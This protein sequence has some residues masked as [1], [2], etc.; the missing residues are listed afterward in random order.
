METYKPEKC[1]AYPCKFKSYYVV[2]K[3]FEELFVPLTERS[4]NRTM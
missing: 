2:W 3:R 1:R 4:L